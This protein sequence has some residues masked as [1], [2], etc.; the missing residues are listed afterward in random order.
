MHSRMLVKRSIGVAVVLFW[1]LMNVLLLRRQLWAP[2]PPIAVHGAEK[3]TGRIEEWWGVFYHGEKIGH[4]MQIIAPKTDGYEIRD[5]SVLRLQLLGTTQT[6]VMQT[7]MDVDSEWTLKNFD[8]ELQSGD[9]RFKA[10]GH[11][12]P[13][14]LAVEIL[15]AGH[16]ATRDIP[17]VQ[18][19]YLLAALKP[20]I[21]T[22]QLEPKKEYHFW[23]FDPAT[24]S[25]QVTT[26][27]IEGREYVRIG[28]RNEP[29]IRVRQQFKGIY[30]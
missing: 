7:A 12:A 26:I 23:T 19:P 29:A 16:T 27:I 30:V 11:V 22:Q 9:M 4:A 14:K 24:L 18:P 15:S 21:A 17:L 2:P 8:F 25:Q 10:R 1:C 13:G 28:N 20:Y 5:Y 3:I 6:A